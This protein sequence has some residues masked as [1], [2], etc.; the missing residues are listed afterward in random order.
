[1]DLFLASGIQIN[2]SVRLM[3]ILMAKCTKTK[4]V[5]E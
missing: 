3:E 4:D 1:M 2:Q 5:V